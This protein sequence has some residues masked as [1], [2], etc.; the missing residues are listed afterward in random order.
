M[1]TTGDATDCLTCKKFTTDLDKLPAKC[2]I[3]TEDNYPTDIA[4][5]LHFSLQAFNYA[6][7]L[8]DWFEM[9][10]AVLQN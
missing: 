8:S 10:R 3:K 7:A 6:T 5:K 4:A 9:Q 1:L 2:K